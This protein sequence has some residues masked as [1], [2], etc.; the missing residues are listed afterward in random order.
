MWE[1]IEI[2]VH[3]SL[4]YLLLSSQMQLEWKFTHCGLGT[5]DGGG[6]LFLVV[7]SEHDSENTIDFTELFFFFGDTLPSVNHALT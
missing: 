3:V 2:Y 5:E 7:L 6:L 1:L 4:E